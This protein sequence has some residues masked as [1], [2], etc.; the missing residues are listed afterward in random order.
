MNKMECKKLQYTIGTVPKYKRKIVKTRA[1]LVPL[2]H[3]CITA[4]FFGLV[5]GF[6]KPV[7][8]VNYLIMK[9]K[10]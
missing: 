4:S 3:L 9:K 7:A 6:L 10:K 1:M 8:G 5:R 2:A